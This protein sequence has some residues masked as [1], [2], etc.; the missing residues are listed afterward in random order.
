MPL[1]EVAEQDAELLNQL[2][3]SYLKGPKQTTRQ[4]AWGIQRLRELLATLSRPKAD[5]NPA[6]PAQQ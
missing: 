6:T 4:V 5:E 2:A 3:P 1:I